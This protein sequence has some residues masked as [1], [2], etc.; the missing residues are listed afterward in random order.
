MLLV[1]LFEDV[2]HLSRPVMEI[3]IY[4]VVVQIGSIFT[5]LM[6]QFHLQ[7]AVVV[8]RRCHHLPQDCL[9]LGST[10]VVGCMLSLL[11]RMMILISL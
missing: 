8:V 11:S 3:Q 4:F 2:L 1:D 7:P 9:T 10:M 5:S 6:E